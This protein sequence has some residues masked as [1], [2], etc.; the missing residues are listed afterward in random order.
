MTFC[1]PLV[2]GRVQQ[3]HGALCSDLKLTLSQNLIRFIDIDSNDDQD[4]W[5]K[6]IFTKD[7][8][9][10]DLY[11]DDPVILQKQST[12]IKFVEQIEKVPLNKV[13]KATNFFWADYDAIRYGSTKF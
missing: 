4:P 10:K 7:G 8:S 1:A 6:K 13:F 11:L 5:F 2:K 3:F 12:T 9:E